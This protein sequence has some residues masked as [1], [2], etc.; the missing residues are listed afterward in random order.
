MP[1]S[2]VNLLKV[3]AVPVVLYVFLFSIHL[4]G[5][6]FK[7]FGEGFAEGLLTT[8]ANPI[9]GL[10]IGILA[11][12]IVQSSSTTTSIVVGM[13]G[14]GVL[15]VGSAV[16]IIMG[17]NVGTTITNTLVAVGQIGRRE[18]F[19]RAFAG[20]TVHDFFNLMAVAIFLP[21]EL[22]TGYLQ[23][24][25][26]ATSGLLAGVGGA[27]WPNPIQEALQPTL[28]GFQDLLLGL[29][30]DGRWMATAMLLFALVLMF[31][32]LHW[33]VRLMKSLMLGT[34]ERIFHR[35][36]ARN[37]LI[38]IAMGAVMTV[39]VQS[40]SI[41]TSLMVP[42]IGAG[43]LTVAQVFPLTLGANIGTTITALL[44]SLAVERP[45]GTV[46][47]LCHLFFNFSAVLLVFI[48]PVLRRIPIALAEGLAER[49][50]ENK[51]YIPGYLGVVFFGIPG[52]FLLL[53]RWFGG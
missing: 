10:M 12:S 17:A 48:I 20:A 29:G 6:S 47:A 36:I 42:V 52:V 7:L 45:E 40:S 8:T 39:F 31:L 13:V 53:H 24:T 16:P 9:I 33:I 27:K 21:L 2:L 38:A 35:V 3:A 34:V 46:I 11:T 49:A 23:K 32:S 4:L 51:W 25:A 15:G 41:T 50:T 22:A 5:S 18:E 28:H 1:R 19:R 14:S 37:V 44:A 43:V 26:E 30:L